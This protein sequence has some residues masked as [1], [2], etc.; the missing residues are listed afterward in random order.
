MLHV[1]AALAALEKHDAILA[2]VV[3]CRF[4]AGL[5][6]AE[7]ALALG[8]SQRTVERDWARARAYL[9]LALQD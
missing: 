1:D 8:R 4:F 6:S 3:E 7:T 9:V 5:S 2:R